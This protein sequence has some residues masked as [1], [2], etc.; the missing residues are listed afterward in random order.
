MDVPPVLILLFQ[1]LPALIIPPTVI[2]G[3]LKVAQD[4]LEFTIP[5]WVSLTALLL[6]HPVALVW[7]RLYANYAMEKNAAAMGAVPAPRVQQGDLAIVKSILESTKTG[8]PGSSGYTIIVRS[9]FLTTE[10]SR[11]NLP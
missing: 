6:T 5:T 1:L 8:Y 4:F 10:L 7:K 11:R 9:Q 3:T 2:Y